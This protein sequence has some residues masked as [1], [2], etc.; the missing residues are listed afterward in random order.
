MRVYGN[1]SV[2]YVQK[3]PSP[4]ETLAVNADS[5]EVQLKLAEHPSAKVRALLAQYNQDLSLDVVEML[6][7]DKSR[8]VRV[9]LSRN[10][11]LSEEAQLL[12]AEKR[13]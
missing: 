8:S 5:E 4:Q 12:I 6:V 10:A 13:R 3:S 1:Q 9:G 11:N 7:E 2:P